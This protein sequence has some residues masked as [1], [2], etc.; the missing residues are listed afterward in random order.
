LE[1]HTM[2]TTIKGLPGL[3]LRRFEASDHLLTEWGLS[4][5]VDTL[6]RMASE[7]RGPPY[8][9]LGNRAFY[10][11]E[12]LDTWAQGRLS[13][14]LNTAQDVTKT[15]QPRWRARAPKDAPTRQALEA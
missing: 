15:P 13:P 12:A 3:M 4:Y 9:L 14:L 5:T 1:N 10:P 11:I 7:R 6:A 8:H 2:P